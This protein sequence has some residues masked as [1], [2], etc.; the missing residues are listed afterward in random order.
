MYNFYFYFT[1]FYIML[2]SNTLFIIINYTMH[3]KDEISFSSSIF[4]IYILPSSKTIVS[5]SLFSCFSELTLQWYVVTFIAIVSLNAFIVLIPY[6]LLRIHGNL[7]WHH[8]ETPKLR[9][10]QTGDWAFKIAIKYFHNFTLTSNGLSS[11]R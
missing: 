4:V 5:D 7:H 8:S 2:Y 3:F 6:R 9:W 11:Y 1:P 10:R